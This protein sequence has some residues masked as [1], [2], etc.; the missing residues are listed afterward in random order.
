M[1]NIDTVQNELQRYKQTRRLFLPII[2][3]FN[4]GIRASS[5]SMEEAE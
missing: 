2:Y 5:C 3:P 4:F 1:L